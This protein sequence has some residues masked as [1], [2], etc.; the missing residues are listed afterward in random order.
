MIEMPESPFDAIARLLPEGDREYFYRRI[1][2]LRDLNPNDDMLQIAEAMGFLA[3]LIRQ[4]PA[5]I[6]AERIKLEELFENTMAGLERFL[7]AEKIAALLSQSLRQQFEASGLGV[8]GQSLRSTAADLAKALDRFGDPARG[9]LARLNSA[10]ARMQ[11][12]LALSRSLAQDLHRALAI[13]GVGA[14][15]I[16]F[17]LGVLYV[18][19]AA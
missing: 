10:L 12:E 9:A 8:N 11:A 13:V 3:V 15:L 19:W 7:D 1:A 2:H 4:A 5:E 6:A 16:G 18:R 17:F 14:V